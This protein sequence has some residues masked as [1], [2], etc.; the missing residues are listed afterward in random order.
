MDEKIEE[1]AF[2]MVKYLQGS[3]IRRNTMVN[4]TMVINQCMEYMGQINKYKQISLIRNCF[5]HIS[6]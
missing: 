3:S 1:K 2:K 5:D 4:K 6:R